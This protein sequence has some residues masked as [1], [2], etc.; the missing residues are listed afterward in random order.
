MERNEMIMKNI[1]IVKS[2]SRFFIGRGME[3][4][5]IFQAGCIGL[6]EA[7]S[8]YDEKRGK[9][10]TFATWRVR[11][12][13]LDEMR[14]NS[15]KNSLEIESHEFINEL[16]SKDIMEKLMRCLTEKERNVIISH[17]LK[18]ESLRTIASRMNQTG[19]N[20]GIVKKRALK[21]MRFAFSKMNIPK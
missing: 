3:Y 4:D 21:K 10:R 13:I 14:K 15:R 20:I 16:I 9:F 17:F 19:E 2:I 6:I 18:D 5:D 12:A 1:W 7:I 8:R 11:G